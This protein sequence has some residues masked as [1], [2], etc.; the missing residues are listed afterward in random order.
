M[1]IEVSMSE[2]EK[3]AKLIRYCIIAGIV[4]FV[5]ALFIIH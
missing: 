2:F 1:I 5:L 3:L 4:C